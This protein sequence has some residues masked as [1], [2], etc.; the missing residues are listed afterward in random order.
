MHEGV[1]IVVIDAHEVAAVQQ[2]AVALVQLDPRR[3]RGELVVGERE[4]VPLD[5]EVAEQRRR[6]PE[7]QRLGAAGGVRC[8]RPDV[9]PDHLQ[10]DQH[11]GVALDRLALEGVVA[12]AGPHPLGALEDAE[13]D[14]GAAR[15]AALE[16]DVGMAPAQ[17]VEQPVER[18]RLCVRAGPPLGAAGLHVVAVHVPLDE[19]DVV[20]AEQGVEAAEDLVVG[21]R[22]GEIE[23]E[24]VST[25]DGS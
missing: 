25:E 2:V 10:G 4:Q 12:V 5:P 23:D 18:Q 1:R 19:G 20:V 6:R 16:L 21:G 3:Q 22:D 9:R 11:R 8:R 14:A 24:L 15:R 13:V 17:L 7:R